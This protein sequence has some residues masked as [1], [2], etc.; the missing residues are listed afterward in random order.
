MNTYQLVFSS[1]GQGEAKVVEFDAED[2]ADALIIAH[3][4]AP[5]R[6]A[7]LWR[8]DEML[9]AIR[10]REVGYWE[11]SQTEQPGA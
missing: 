6:S 7:E 2:A 1:D 10:R 11:L 5:G 4:E 9:C 3:S 8:D